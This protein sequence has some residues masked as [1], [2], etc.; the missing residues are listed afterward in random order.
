MSRLKLN[1]Y[2]LLQARS[3]CSQQN[4]EEIRFVI[5]TQSLKQNNQI[6]IVEVNEESSKLNSI[7]VFSNTLGEAWKINSSPHDNKILACVFSNHNRKGNEP[8]MQTAILRLP[9]TETEDKS[10]EFLEFADIE[11]LNNKPHSGQEIK[12]TEF[13]PS[14]ANL[15]ASVIDGKVLIFNRAESSTKIIAEVTGK[16]SQKFSGGKWSNHHQVQLLFLIV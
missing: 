13:H 2:S 14:N 11:I 9:E 7:S 15:L 10:K 3:L 1:S 12:T 16:N 8:L 5:A 6:H 4:T